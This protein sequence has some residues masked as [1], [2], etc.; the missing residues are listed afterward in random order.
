VP[1]DRLPLRAS[2]LLPVAPAAPAAALPAAAPAAL[3]AVEPAVEP[4]YLL[5]RLLLRLL[6]RL[7]L[8]LTVPMQPAAMACGPLQWRAPHPA[9]LRSGSPPR[10]CW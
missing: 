1:A 9:P 3:P 7:L 10:A 4:A 5:L 6:P 8:R 2:A